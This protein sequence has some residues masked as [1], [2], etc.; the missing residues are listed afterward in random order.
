MISQLLHIAH[1]LFMSIALVG[2]RVK[3]VMAFSRIGVLSVENI[4]FALFF[5]ASY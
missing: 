5:C 2:K 3:V 1:D 4:K